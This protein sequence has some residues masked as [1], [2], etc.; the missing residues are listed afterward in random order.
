MR[1]ILAIDPGTTQS[2]YVLMSD[3]YIPVA[4]DKCLNEEV[5]HRIFTDAS[6]LNHVV[7]EMITSY[8]QSVG[9]ETF[10]TCRWIGRFEGYARNLHIPCDLIPRKDVKKRLCGTQHSNDSTVRKKL[11]ERF[12]AFDK[13]GGKGTKNH[14]D[15]FYGFKADIWQAYALGV[16][17]LDRRN[18][19]VG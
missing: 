18:T 12:A 7:I 17:F 10:E 2:A 13:E 11:I 9:Q 3:D 4:F 14:P 16:C 8:G 6:L 15:W 1:L 5:E 19:N